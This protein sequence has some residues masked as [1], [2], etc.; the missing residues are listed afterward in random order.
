MRLDKCDVYTVKKITKCLWQDKEIKE[1]GARR[2]ETRVSRWGS[3]RR[4]PSAIFNLVAKDSRMWK[5]E[6]TFSV[7]QEDDQEP[8]LEVLLSTGFKIDK[9]K[10]SSEM[11]PKSDLQKITPQ[12]RDQKQKRCKMH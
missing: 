2:R 11:L 8:I 5:Q 10:K 4:L 12:Q 3:N 6:N 1:S 7:L 9:D